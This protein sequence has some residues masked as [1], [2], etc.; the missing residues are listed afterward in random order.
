[1][2]IMGKIKIFLDLIKF[3]HSIFALPFAYLGLFIAEGGFPRPR[4]LL[5][6]T[7]AMVAIRTAGMCFNRLI[8]QTIDEKNPRTRGRGEAI[9]LIKPWRLWFITAVAILMFIFAASRLNRLCFVLSPVP[10]VLVW[11]YPHLKKITWLSHFVLGIIL[12]LAPF[13]GWLASRSEWSWTP[14]LLSLAVW[15][16]VSGF[17]MF[18]ALQDLD[19]D[20]SNGLKSIPAQFGIP[21]TILMVRFLHGLTII[22]LMFLGTRLELGF[23][24]WLGWTAVLALTVREHHLVARFGLAKIDEAFFDMNAWVSVVIFAAVALELMA[25]PMGIR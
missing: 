22:A 15:A 20:R 8:D 12:G 24:Y 17:D 21:T 10:I 23:W 9:S 4:I 3:E 2:R 16:W 13:A 14:A 19:F 11:I 6:V 25:H 18:Y 1:M 5:W 7:V